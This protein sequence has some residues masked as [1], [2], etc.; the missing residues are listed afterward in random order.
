MLCVWLDYELTSIK[1]NQ[2][3]ILQWTQVCNRIMHKAALVD[4][5]IGEKCYR[6]RYWLSRRYFALL[7]HFSPIAYYHATRAVCGAFSCSRP[8]SSDN[9]C[10]D[11][12]GATVFTQVTSYT[13]LAFISSP[14]PFVTMTHTSKN[15]FM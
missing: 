1:S 14:L 13:I 12:E 5:A 15:K 3:W 11:I 8:L 4:G 7:W 10:K 2:L 6:E 9:A